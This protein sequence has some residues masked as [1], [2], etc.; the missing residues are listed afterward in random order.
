MCVIEIHA[1]IEPNSITTATVYYAIQSDHG[2]RDLLMRPKLLITHLK[3]LEQIVCL[4]S[5]I[6]SHVRERWIILI[7][8][9]ILIPILSLE[10][11]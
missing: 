8:T 1:H 9:T 6:F 4:L 3:E 5:Y 10:Q 11:D 2:I 7:Q